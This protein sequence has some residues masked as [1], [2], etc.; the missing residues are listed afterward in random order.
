MLNCIYC[1]SDETKLVKTFEMFEIYECKKCHSK[2]K[3]E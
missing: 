1:K 3:V 2:F